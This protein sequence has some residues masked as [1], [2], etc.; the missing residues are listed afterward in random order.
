MKSLEKIDCHQEITVETAVRADAFVSVWEELLKIIECI[1]HIAISL[2]WRLTGKKTRP[3]PAINHNFLWIRN[4]REGE[5]ME[6]QKERQTD[7]DIY[8]L[9]SRNV[10]I[11]TVLER[12]RN[13]MHH[14]NTQSRKLPFLFLISQKHST[15]LCFCHVTQG[16]RTLLV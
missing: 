4:V 11:S 10:M 9:I 16:H 5:S 2:E 3:W 7:L 1:I 8:L 6:W 12:T 15:L 13:Q 14:W